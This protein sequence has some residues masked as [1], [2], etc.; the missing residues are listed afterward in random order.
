MCGIGPRRQESELGWGCS[1]R[2]GRE[3][4]SPFQLPGLVACRVLGLPPPAWSSHAG[5]S[6]RQA[7][8]QVQEGQHL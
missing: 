1:G 4:P 2:E 5:G 3:A 7:Q 8:A 6:P